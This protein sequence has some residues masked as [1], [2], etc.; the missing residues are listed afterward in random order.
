[1]R[2]LFPEIS[3]DADINQGKV[4]K[5]FPVAAGVA[6]GICGVAVLAGMGVLLKK[7]MAKKK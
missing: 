3:R 7:Y 6:I 2:L 5:G 1:M 4:K